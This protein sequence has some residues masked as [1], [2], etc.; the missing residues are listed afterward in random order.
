M[1]KYFSIIIL[2]AMLLILASCS[3]QY[4][5]NLRINFKNDKS[6]NSGYV[7]AVYEDRIYYVSNELGTAGIYSMKPDGSDV[8]M[9]AENP[10]ITSLQLCDGILYFDGLYRIN[11]RHGSIQTSTIN[12]HTI[13]S[14]DLGGNPTRANY[15]HRNYNIKGFYVSQNGYILAR[16]GALMEDL[17]MFDPAFSESFSVIDN[18]IATISLEYTSKNELYSDEYGMEESNEDENIILKS[19]YQFGDFI[20]VAEHVPGDHDYNWISGDPYVLDSNTG[21]LVLSFDRRQGDALKALY[22]DESSIF[23]SYKEMVVIIDR[24]T[25]Q[26]RTTF[27]PEGISDEYHIVHMSKYGNSVYMIADYWRDQ[28]EKTPPLM[29]EKIYIM[30][31]KTFE[32]KELLNLGSN[33][34]VIGMDENF[35]ILLDDGV[36]YK[37][38]PD[39]GNPDDRIKLCDAPADIYSKNHAID[40]AGDWMFVYKIYPENGPF[41]YGSDLPGQQLLMKVNLSSGEIIHNDIELDFSVLDSYKNNDS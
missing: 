10:S 19:I 31:S 7:A 40:Y 9:E 33:Q 11:K 14:C 38:N 28:D 34:R 25:Y 26:V 39:N 41:T 5:D 17:H 37:M 2:V 3:P 13:Y 16:Y 1:K 21:E 36:I 12:D 15:V 4:P 23:C 22:M 8:R 24:A 30:D 27:I 32:S 29:G 6:S 18:K 35:I 20:F